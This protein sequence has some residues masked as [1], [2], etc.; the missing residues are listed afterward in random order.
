MK[1]R[2]PTAK[3][4]TKVEGVD[5]TEFESGELSSDLPEWDGSMGDGDGKQAF[6]AGSRPSLSLSGGVALRGGIT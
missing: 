1:S 2:K 5:G 4:L 3:F 6:G